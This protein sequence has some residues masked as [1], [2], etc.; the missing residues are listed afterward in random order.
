MGQLV[1]TIVGGVIGFLIG[2]PMGASIGMALGGMIGATLFGPTIK[3][4]RLNDLKVSSSTYGIVIPEIYGTVRLSTNLIWTTGITETKKT[5]RAGKGGPKVETYEYDA[6]FALGIC[7]G[8]I[9]EILRIWADSKLIYDVS[10]NGTRNP[11]SVSQSGIIAPILLSFRT[12]SRKKK[13]INMRIY[14]GN[15]EQ[16]PDSLIEADKGVGNVSA[17]RG[18]AYVVFERMPLLDF[19][20]RIPQFTMEVTKAP[21][22]AFPSVEVK[23]GPAGTAAKPDGRNWFPDWENGKI[24]SSIITND[25]AESYTQVFDLNTMQTMQRW[26]TSSMWFAAARY[27]F[28]PWAGV[29]VSDIGSTNGR[30]LG[31]FSLATGARIDLFGQLSSSFSG[32]YVES[33]PDKGALGLSANFGN[34][35]T[36]S[37]DGK[38]IVLAGWFQDN[39]IITPGGEPRGWY[40]SAWSPQ[41]L[42][43]AL[44]SVWGWRNGNGGLQLADFLIG[45]LDAYELEP[46]AANGN[47]LWK[48]GGG[49]A[50]NTTLKPLPGETFLASVCLF[51][52]SDGYFFCIGRSNNGLRSIPVTFKYNPLT[53]LYK[54]IK[55]NPAMLVPNGPMQWSRLNGGTFGYIADQLNRDK[56]N[57][58][59]INLQNGELVKDVPYNNTWGGAI[60][61]KEDQHWDDVSSSIVTTTK[62]SF[63]RIWFNNNAKE[64]RLSDVVRDIATKANVLTVD[65]LDTNGLVDEVIIGFSIDR[66]SSASDALKLLATG[67]M[68]DAYESD[69][70][71]KFRTRG[72]ESEAV[73]P[74]DWLARSDGGVIKENIVQELEMPLKVTVN[75]YDTSR[76][77][78]QGSQSSRRNA[79]P[80]PTM[81]TAKEDIIDLP[82]VWTPDMAKRSADKLLKMAWANRTGLQFRLPWRYLKYEPSDVITVTTENAVYFTRMTEVT[83]G[84]DFSIEAAGVTEKSSAYVSTKIGS[85]TDSPEQSIE[86]GFPAFPIVINTPLLRDQD[87]DSSGA[88]VCFVS[89]GTNAF[90]FSGA[91]I[92]VYDGLEDQR[93]GFVGADTVRGRTINKL[94]YTTAYESTDETTVLKVVLTNPDD[95]LESVTQLDMLNFDMNAALVGEEI[96]QFREATQQPN[97][98]WWLTG[99]RRARRGTNYALKTHKPNEIFLLLAPEAITSF[100]RP[101]EAYVTTTEMRALTAG[102]IISD[103]LP[104]VASLQPRDLMPYTPEDIKIDDDGAS[105]T[106]TVQRRSRIIAPLRDGISNIHFKEGVKQT[107]KISCQLWPGRGFEVIDSGLPPTLVENVPIFD[108]NGQDLVLEINFP[109]AVLGASTKFVARITEQGTVDGIAKWVAF[110]RLS[111]GRWNQTEFY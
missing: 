29:F 25:A 62:G 52:P 40:R 33:G 28:A 43:P 90:T 61:V 51:D 34:Q 79:G 11:L 6:S 47:V 10:N 18:I 64:V 21:A 71:L 83:I 111:E 82:L 86:D 5:R 67:Y 109:L 55:S 19:G 3:G 59:Q 22:E 88:S 49:L 27:G 38:F 26:D 30:Q 95:E 54:F 53:G 93:I 81:W 68:F 8:P 101:P 15:E 2:G 60:F 35:A 98:E 77:H 31:V 24:F 48:Q 16:L 57:L 13:R 100:V 36:I 91:A 37:L 104:V 87:Y 96:I 66:Q 14:L 42:F 4:P 70:K 41:H 69:Y 32:Y 50:F 99:L 105:V 39:W 107:S 56:P 46:P 73:I 110:E 92:Y 1:T 58:Q 108:S 7:K 75:Y 89:A 74:E 63:R 85:R 23:E 45:G 9:R 76:D 84:Q 72:R 65:D 78:Q 44:G 20:N 94:P 17:H 102:Q 97:G 103:A 12:G 106:I 80:F